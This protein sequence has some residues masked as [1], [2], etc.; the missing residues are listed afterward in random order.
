MFAA[1]GAAKFAV[2]S[3][4]QTAGKQYYSHF[5]CFAIRKC[6][7]FDRLTYD[8]ASS[9]IRK[10]RDSGERVCSGCDPYSAS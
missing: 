9:R 6:R 2:R 5:E 4:T 1:Y 3:L 8:I 7:H 10:A